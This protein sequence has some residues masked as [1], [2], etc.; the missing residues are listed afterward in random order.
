MAKFEFN[1]DAVAKTPVAPKPGEFTKEYIQYMLHTNSTWLW[2]AILAIYNRQEL[3]E[4]AMGATIKKNGI[5]FNGAD[6]DIMS[7]FAEQIIRWQSGQ[8]NFRSPLSPKQFNIARS[9]MIKYAG[10]LVNI[11]NSKKEED[12]GK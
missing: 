9:K 6:A 12:D 8:S 5:G 1:A 2:R 7:S 3:D 11:A 10:Q 4:K